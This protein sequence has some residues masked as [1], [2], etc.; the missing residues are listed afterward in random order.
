MAELFL[1]VTRF[2][3]KPGMEDQARALLEKEL[4]PRKRRLHEVVPGM[5][6][7]G[8]MRSKQQPIY[9]L[10]VVWENEQAFH[11]TQHN[12]KAKDGGGLPA[13]LAEYCDGVFESES[14]YLERL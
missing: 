13:R 12:P 7:I 8:L 2:N 10:A 4:R 1:T 6:G 11:D 5:L 3:V 9:G 14:F